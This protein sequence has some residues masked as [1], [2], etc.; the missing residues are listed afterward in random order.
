MGLLGLDVRVEEG[1]AVAVDASCSTRPR[2]GTRSTWTRPAPNSKPPFSRSHVS[3]TTSPEHWAEI[4]GNRSPYA[5][6]YSD[7]IG[8]LIGCVRRQRRGPSVGAALLPVARA[9]SKYR[10]VCIVAID[11]FID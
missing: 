7:E 4:L 1:A 2:C 8:T 6:Q 9:S 10:H 11:N 5:G 3:R